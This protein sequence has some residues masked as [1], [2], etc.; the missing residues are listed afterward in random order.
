MQT[1]TPKTAFLKQIRANAL[2]ITI[3]I[4]LVIGLLSMLFILQGYY[5]KTSQARYFLDEKLNNNLN[6]GITICLADTN[7]NEPGKVKQIDLYGKGNDSLMVDRYFWGVYQ[8]GICKVW[9]QGSEK[10][11]E[12]MIGS[13]FPGFLNSCLYL[14][15]HDR[16]LSVV[17][18]TELVGDAYLPKA[19]VRMAYINQNGYSGA[20]LVY[21]DILFSDRIPPAIYDG[22]FQY[23]DT[24][25]FSAQLFSD[26]E[27]SSSNNLE[28]T[29]RSFSDSLKVIYDRGKMDISNISYSGHII[30]KSD[31]LIE[32]ENTCAL[33]NVICIAPRVRIKSG[34]KGRIQVLASEGITMEDSCALQ[35]PSAL[36][37]IKRNQGVARSQPTI[38]VERNSMLEGGIYSFSGS[39][40]VYKTRVIVEDSCRL[41]GILF[42]NGYL[43]LKS[44]ITGS[45]LTDFMLYQNNSSTYENHLVDIKIDR[46]GLSDHFLGPSVFP[47]PKQN[48]VIQWLN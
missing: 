43:T 10:Q 5:S 21:G 33:Q 48:K 3:I 34:F 42:V 44:N 22:F 35:Y 15:D 19:G 4:S 14:V 18:R 29:S 39:D 6:S 9:A 27:N 45:V 32:I 24:L 40:D 47:G 28:T 13:T 12:M 16:P 8:I 2:S 26:L 38:T 25:L 20:K 23:L 1:R 36:I 46:S 37:L 30:I 41:N 11:K 7:Q 31:S 17:G